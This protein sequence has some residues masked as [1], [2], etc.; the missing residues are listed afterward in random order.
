MT[1][2]KQ[3]KTKKLNTETT[4]KTVDDIEWPLRGFLAVA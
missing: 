4:I 2:Q 3:V 1:K